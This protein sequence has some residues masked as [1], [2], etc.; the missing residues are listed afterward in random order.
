M[1]LV[2]SAMEKIRIVV[3]SPVD[4]R[5]LAMIADAGDWIRMDYLWPL[6][7]AARKGDERAKASLDSLLAE[8]EVLYGWLRVLPERLPSRAPVLKWIQ[9]MSAGVDELP[10]EVR[11]SP[12]VLTN[13]SG[14]HAVPIGE[15]ILGVMLMF[16]KQAPL[17]FEQKRQKQYKG[18][19]PGLLRGRT[20]GIV[21]LGHIGRETA[22]LA[23]AFGMRVCAT[24]R[25]AKPGD[26]ARYVDKVFP[27]SELLGL[28]AESDF[29]VLSLPLT[30]ETRGMI[31]ERELRAVQPEAYLINVAR[32]AVVDEDVLV[33]ALQEGWIAGAGLDVF[34]KEPLPEE[35]GLW[36]LP[37]VILS[38]HITG[39]MPDYLEQATRL[40]CENLERYRAGKRLLHR[41]DKARGY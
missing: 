11:Q 8:A 1:G 31:G 9:T 12:I 33:R 6:M 17:C 28:L 39:L 40:F 29:V 25:S 14:L 5:S 26:R 21:G 35:S 15:F 23:K 38:P 18:F 41:V 37:N 34:T 20:L 13:V 30:A 4:D 7:G 19:S 2:R 22:R 3:S 32:G 36:D 27:L 16:V 10:E 24:R